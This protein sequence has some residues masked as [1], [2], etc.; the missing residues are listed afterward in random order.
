MLLQVRRALTITITR[1]TAGTSS[2]APSTA[3][4][5][6]RRY[7][8]DGPWPLVLVV[9]TCVHMGLP[10]HFPYV[11]RTHRVPTRHCFVIVGVTAGV[12]G[13]FWQAQRSALQLPYVGFATTTDIQRALHPPDKQVG[14]YLGLCGCWL[15]TTRLVRTLAVHHPFHS[16]RKVTPVM[17]VT[18]CRRPRGARGQAPGVRHPEQDR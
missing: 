9:L 17:R 4:R 3:P 14:V 8:T 12:Q 11:C 7:R 16:T 5:S 18:G 15:C 10:A 13:D 6:R 2:S 1:N